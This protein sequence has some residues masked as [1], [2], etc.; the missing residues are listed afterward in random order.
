MVD[1]VSAVRYNSGNTKGNEM[2]D[3]CYN[4]RIR[5]VVRFEN[6]EKKEKYFTIRTDGS[7]DDMTK[8]ANEL[9]KKDFGKIINNSW[10]YA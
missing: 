4:Q 2:N 10:Y 3:C 1:T 6:G 9:V 8:Q 5:I 7:F